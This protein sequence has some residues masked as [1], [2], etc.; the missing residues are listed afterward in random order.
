M[1]D[2]VHS[3]GSKQEEPE[4]K[5]PNLVLYYSLIALAFATAI[6]LALLIVRP[7]YLRR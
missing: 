7:F 4:P 6:G 2:N 3:G 5:G 1:N